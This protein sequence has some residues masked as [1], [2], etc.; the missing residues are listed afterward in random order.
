MGWYVN[1]STHGVQ[2]QRRTQFIY[3]LDNNFGHERAFKFASNT[4]KKTFINDPVCW[5]LEESAW[6][7]YPSRS[8]PSP[9]FRSPP[10]TQPAWRTWSAPRI[11]SRIQQS[12]D[13]SGQE[14]IP[15][16][17]VRFQLNSE[18]LGSVPSLY[19]MVGRHRRSFD[20]FEP[21]LAH[22]ECRCSTRETTC[23]SWWQ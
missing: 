9:L 12:R 21:V 3:A 5:T 2:G 11:S 7:W 16:I 19:A 8:V 18:S 13:L 6:L 4:I 15:A 23:T 10:G 22:N 20:D 14:K 1:N 17:P